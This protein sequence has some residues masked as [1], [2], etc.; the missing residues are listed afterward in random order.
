MLLLFLCDDIAQN[1]IFYFLLDLLTWFLDESWN[2]SCGPVVKFSIIT[3][4]VNTKE[5]QP[6][7]GNKHKMCQLVYIHLVLSATSGVS[8][9]PFM[10]LFGKSQLLQIYINIRG[11]VWI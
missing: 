3:F 4:P 7:P 5:L 6:N 9:L 8:V 11:C 10:L 2:V 1:S